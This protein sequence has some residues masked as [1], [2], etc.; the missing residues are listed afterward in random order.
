MAL[1]NE[2]QYWSPGGQIYYWF[3][4]A[5]GLTGKE[6]QSRRLAVYMG[7]ESQVKEA[8][9]NG[10]RSVHPIVNKTLDRERAL[11]TKA[12]SGNGQ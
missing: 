9:S 1:S 10:R 5:Y 8:L 12:R 4:K 11:L 6:Q 2:L 3:G 7:T